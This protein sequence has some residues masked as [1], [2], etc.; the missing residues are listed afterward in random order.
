MLDTLTSVGEALKKI[1][2]DK[3]F[4]LQE[5]AD[6]TTIN[7]TLLSRIENGKKLPTK[8][9]VKKLALF[10]N[11]NENDLI[12]NLISDKIIY[13]I[14]NEDFGLE[15]FQLAEQ[16]IKYGIS[17]FT[18]YK[19]IEKIKI[20]S[21]RYIGNKA[22]LT[23][24]I[25]GII[26]KETQ[27]I[28]TFID[29]FSGTASVARKAMQKYNRVIVNDILYSNNVIYKAFFK[30]EFW[31][32]EK[33]TEII[34]NYNTLEEGK[35][36]E[37]YFSKQ[38]GGKF[39]EL[40]TAKK[41][42][43]IRQD[44]ENH[45][46]ELTQ[47]EYTIL[48]ATLIYNIDKIANTVGHFEA[49]IKKPIKKNPLILKIIKT[50]DFKNIEIYRE[51]ANKLSRKIKGDIAYIDPPYNSRQYSRFYHVYENL[52]KWEKP[53]LYGVTLKPEPENMSKYCTVKISLL[54]FLL[55]QNN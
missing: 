1:R 35:I 41:I 20:E 45:K 50:E 31:D 28:E 46:N 26:E 9:Q 3:G 10:Y 53:K 49:Y 30:S 32:K 52:V 55:L 54:S 6:E 16:K 19:N 17:L 39:F 2:K 13:K 11:F 7:Y 21:R 14:K 25:I 23:D 47:K 33:I 51:D 38:F 12:K 29:V 5:V 24:W 34:Y 15:G 18:E 42:G 27:N 37:N 43:Y 36:K 22:K 44:I 4:Y 8:G 48:I 40:E